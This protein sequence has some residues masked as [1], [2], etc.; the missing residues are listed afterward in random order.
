MDSKFKIPLIILL[1]GIAITI[2]GA[3]F[4]IMYWQFASGLLILGMSLEVAGI[5][6]LAL[7]LMKK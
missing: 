4:K 5:L 3:L 1:F 2:L 7:K 6:S